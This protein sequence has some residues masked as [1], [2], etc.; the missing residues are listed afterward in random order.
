MNQF[1]EYLN[2]LLPRER[3]HFALNFGGLLI[4][5]GLGQMTKI[6]CPVLCLPLY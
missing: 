4:L 5:K 2:G 3:I 6:I 1:V